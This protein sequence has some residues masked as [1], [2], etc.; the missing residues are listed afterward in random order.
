M[1]IWWD[2][3]RFLGGFVEQLNVRFAAMPTV[4]Q[5]EGSREE[6]RFGGIEELAALQQEF[7]IFAPDVPFGKSA[8]VLGMGGAE[9][10]RCKNRWIQL[11][12]SLHRFAAVVDGTPAEQNGNDAIVA[13]VMAALGAT[14]PTPVY[15]KVHDYGDQADGKVLID[16]NAQPAFFLL[17]SGSYT[18]ISLPLQSRASY[19][20]KNPGAPQGGKPADSVKPKKPG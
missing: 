12:S 7:S 8:S 14:P 13:A 5:V 1:G 16:H 2:C 4:H 15:F 11:L 18:T 6:D 9:N 3:E 17:G 19:L 10:L 20:R